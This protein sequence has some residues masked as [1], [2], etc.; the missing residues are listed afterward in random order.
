MFAGSLFGFLQAL[1]VMLMGM[2]GNQ[3]A[4]SLISYFV[5]GVLAD[6]VYILLGQK[7]NVAT[8]VIV[9]ALANVCG[10]VLVAIGIFSHPPLLVLAVAGIALLSGIGGGLMSYWL[11][12]QLIKL[13]VIA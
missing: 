2:M 12:K 7:D 11:H 5:P 4:F 6:V 8:Q 10:A 13:G 3:G 1:I 9:C